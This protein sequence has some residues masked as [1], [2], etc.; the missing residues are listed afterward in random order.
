[1]LTNSSQIIRYGLKMFTKV[2]SI[3]MFEMLINK[4]FLM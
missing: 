1:M 2:T 3:N 4:L